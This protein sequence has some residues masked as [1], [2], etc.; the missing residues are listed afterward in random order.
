MS[1]RISS[2]SSGV[3]RRACTRRTVSASGVGAG[4]HP[5]LELPDASRGSDRSG[6]CK[7]VHGRRYGARRL[8]SHEP[9]GGER[10][11]A[12]ARRCPGARGG[13]LHR[14][15][16]QPRLP[17]V[18][19]AP[20]G[21]RDDGGTPDERAARVHEH[22]LQAARRLQAP[23][24]RRRV[25]YAT[26]PPARGLGGVQGRTPADAGS[27]AGA[28]PALPSARRGVRLPEPRVR[29][30]GGRRRDR[31]RGDARRRGRAQDVRRLDRP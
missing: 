30:L 29:R 26:G 9:E 22:A 27:P 12:A 8:A 2:T 18:L 24:R 20:R 17:G 16:Q 5:A 19:R 14:R 21:A 13:A 4:S 28:V 3:A 31:D 15:R 1:E 7:R 11:G 10:G 25:G 6:P 23:R